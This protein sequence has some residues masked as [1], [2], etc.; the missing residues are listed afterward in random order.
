MTTSRSR[1]PSTRRKSAC[2]TA[3][4]GLAG[5]RAT[6]VVPG[7]PA[8]LAARPEGRRRASPRRRGAAAQPRDEITYRVDPPITSAE[9]MNARMEVLT[10]QLTGVTARLNDLVD[11]LVALMATGASLRSEVGEES[12]ANG[13]PA[14]RDPRPDDGSVAGS[15]LPTI[16][17]PG[18]AF[19]PPTRRVRYQQLVD[20]V[21]DA[22]RRTVSSGSR[23]VVISKGDDDLVRLGS[24]NASHFPQTESG[25]YAGY[26]P[27]DSAAAI[28]HLEMV[29]AKGVNYLV[30]PSTAYWW[31][32]HYAEFRDHLETRY[33][34]VIRD[35][36]C[37]IYDLSAQAFKALAPDSE[38]TIR[39]QQ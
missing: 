19:T 20:R 35:K 15:R 4:P 2:L 32:S 1:S 6:P 17:L 13:A 16:V 31:F 24:L 5:Q 22:I 8:C 7:P 38:F 30:V 3:T 34:A 23:V 28:D 10:D 11:A 27:A 12:V 9:A 36:D 39:R 33:R 14:R 25:T 21:R 18:A 29:R 26:H 37:T